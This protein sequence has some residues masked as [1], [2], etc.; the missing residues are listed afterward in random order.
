MSVPSTER[1][2]YDHVAAARRVLAYLAFF[3]DDVIG[4]K[5]ADGPPLHFSDL[6]TLAQYAVQEHLES[7]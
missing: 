6:K 5:N 4:A 7:P 2:P 3:G 1:E